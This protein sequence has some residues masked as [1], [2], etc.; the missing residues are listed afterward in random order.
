MDFPF[1]FYINFSLILIIMSYQNLHSNM[2]FQ[3]Q[4]GET[5]WLMLLLKEIN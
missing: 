4:F 5:F 1:D 3:S 2:L